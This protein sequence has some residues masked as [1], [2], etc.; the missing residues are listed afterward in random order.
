MLRGVGYVNRRRPDFFTIVISKDSLLSET[1]SP[2]PATSSPLK[3][4]YSNWQLSHPPLYPLFA[5]LGV[6]GVLPHLSIL[7][8]LFSIPYSLFSIPYSLFSIPYSL[9]SIPYS[10]FSIP[11]SLFSIPYSLHQKLPYRLY[12]ILFKLTFQ[13]VKR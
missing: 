3:S 11:Y 1:I 13:L 10:L 4:Y 7:Y 8:S 6:L 12:L 9:F 5:L 2:P